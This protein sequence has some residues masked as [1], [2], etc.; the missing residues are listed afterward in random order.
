MVKASPAW[1]QILVLTAPG[2][3]SKNKGSTWHKGCGSEKWAFSLNV[4]SRLGGGCMVRGEPIRARFDAM[5]RVR[6][7]KHR[8]IGFYQESHWVG[9]LGHSGRLR[10]ILPEVK[11]VPAVTN[12]PGWK[13][14]CG[15]LLPSFLTLS[16]LSLPVCSL[17]SSFPGGFYLRFL[18]GFLHCSETSYYVYIFTAPTQMFQ[19]SEE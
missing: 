16:S 5:G 17:R 8:C 12:R 14:G 9:D 19:H 15:D 7:A 3:K 6:T 18:V 1:R 13:D 2:I 10:Q 4:S 11:T